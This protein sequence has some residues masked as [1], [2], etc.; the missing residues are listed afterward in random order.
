MTIESLG[1]IPILIAFGF[2]ALSFVSPCVLPLLP[3][4]LS[5]MSGYSVNDLQEGKASTARMARVT[6]LFIAGFTAVF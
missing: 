4:Y 2:G 5:L 6:L 3:G 1:L